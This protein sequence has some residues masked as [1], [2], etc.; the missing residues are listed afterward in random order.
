MIIIYVILGF[1]AAVV[2]YLLIAPL[3]L[4]I[5][6]KKRLF[7]V[8]FHRIGSARLNLGD[9]SLLLQLRILGIGREIDLLTPRK[10]GA[11]KP[12][13]QAKSTSPPLRKV[14]AV[15]RSFKVN[16][17]SLQL[18]TGDMALNGLL[19]PLVTTAGWLMNREVGINFA[20]RNEFVLEIENNAL[21]MVRAYLF[22]TQNN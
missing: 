20:A 17:L 3:Y 18:D 6:S 11:K 22:T 13:Q 2:A 8:R 7:Q 5:N 1:L 15:I 14:L 16:Q 4:E 19:F 12:N 21:R 9:N 10:A